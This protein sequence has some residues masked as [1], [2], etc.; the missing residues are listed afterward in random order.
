MIAEKRSVG[1]YVAINSHLKLFA[2]WTGANRSVAT[3]N[4]TM[5]EDFHTH[6]LGRTELSDDYKKD[7]IGTVKQYVRW[8]VE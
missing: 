7:I 8:C 3:M 5:L 6:L 2:E 1:R 4:A